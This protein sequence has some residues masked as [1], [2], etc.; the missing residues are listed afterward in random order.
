MAIA[1]SLGYK[2]KGISTR[3]SAIYNKDKDFCMKWI[4]FL[5]DGKEDPRPKTDETKVDEIEDVPK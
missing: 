3:I 5:I 1:E 2:L 4:K